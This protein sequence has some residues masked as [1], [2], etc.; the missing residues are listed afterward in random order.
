[1]AKICPGDKAAPFMM[2]GCDQMLSLELS[3]DWDAFFTHNNQVR[4]V[5]EQRVGLKSRSAVMDATC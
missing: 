4:L 5:V 1:V 3:P 2:M